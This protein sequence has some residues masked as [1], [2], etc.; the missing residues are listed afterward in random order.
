MMKPSFDLTSGVSGTVQ[1]GPA[2][3]EVRVPLSG[4]S[5][6][7]KKKAEVAL[8]A[9]LAEHP[10]PGVGDAHS[11]VEGVV[12][13]VEPGYIAVEP[14]SL[15][16]EP[17]PA[18]N[19]GGEE[20]EGE[21]PKKAAKKK[22]EKVPAENIDITNLAGDELLAALK[23]LGVDTGGFSRAATLI[24]NGVN[25]EPGVS[26]AEQIL[27][28]NRETLE[29]G[30]EALQKIVSASTTALA[31]AEGSGASLSGASTAYVKPVY[32]NSVD[33]LVIKAVTGR[34]TQ[35]GVTVVSVHDL[36]AVGKVAETGSPVTETII[37]VGGINYLLKVGTPVADLLKHAGLSAQAGDRVVL[38]GPMRGEAIYSTDQGVGKRDFGLCVI[39][40]DAFPPVTDT[41]CLN[42]GQC[43]QYCP[44]RLMPNMLGRFAEFKMFAKAREYGLDAC[45]ECGMCGYY[46]TA[47]RPLLQYIRLAKSELAAMEAPEETEAPE[48]EAAA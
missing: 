32:P 41:A 31:V 28:D 9:K 15:S 25:P 44:A 21:K 39:P 24:I 40:K 42:C 14:R 36:Y 38:G 2:P 17:E 37:T 1:D 10:D 8:G 13:G 18:E 43:V 12:T 16:P 27:K 5:T 11:P 3:A 45:F 19:S 48:E 34:E 47:R 26:A 20:A 29:K 33:P 30:L 46:C 4:H 22:V 6:K 23:S 35:D 7:L